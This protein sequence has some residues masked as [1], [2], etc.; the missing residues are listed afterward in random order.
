AYPLLLGASGPAIALY[1]D[2]P[3]LASQLLIRKGFT[4]IAESDLRG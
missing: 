2:D 1:V 3:T 4:L